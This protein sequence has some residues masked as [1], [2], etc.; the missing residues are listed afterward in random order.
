MLRSREIEIIAYSVPAVRKDLCSLF[1]CVAQCAAFSTKCIPGSNLNA[2]QG[3]V[4]PLLALSY[5]QQQKLRFFVICALRAASEIFAF[6]TV[7]SSSFLNPHGMT[8]RLAS[9]V[10]VSVSRDQHASLR[11]KLHILGSYFVFVW[12]RSF[13][14]CRTSESG[15]I[16]QPAE[17][18]T[19]YPGTLFFGSCSPLTYSYFICK[20]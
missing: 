5:P 20:P 2:K 1:P 7:L 19:R 17:N 13:P 6:P 18:S 15:V 3:Y 8:A 9:R 11:L 10:R 14:N 12:D 4:V 16:F